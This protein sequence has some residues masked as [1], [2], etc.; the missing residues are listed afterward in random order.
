VKRSARRI[1]TTH[2]GSLARPLDL[3]E[4]IR[5]KE[6][7]QAVNDGEFEDR[8]RLAVE[9]IVKMQADCGIDV[10]SDGEQRRPSFNS[11]VLSRLTGFEIGQGEAA[12]T[13]WGQSA[14]K[15]IFA[16]FYKLFDETSNQGRVASPQ[17]ICTG[18]I[19]Y[20]DAAIKRDLENLR[21]AVSKIECEEAFMPAI[22]STAIAL[23]RKNFFYKSEE[24]YQIALADAMRSEYSAIVNAGFIVQVDDPRLVSHYAMTEKLPTIDE[25]R[26]WAARR[27][28]MINYSLQGIPEDKVRFHT[29]YSIDIGPRIHDLELKHIVDV[30]CGIRAGA[31]S[32]EFS[33][34]RHEH[35]WSVWKNAPLRDGTVLIPG[36]ISH[37]TN[38][39]E[40][41]ELIAERISRFAS[42]V[43][44][45]NVIAGAD[46]G[47]A[48]GASVNQIIHPSV[49]KAKLEA[50]SAGARIASAKLWNA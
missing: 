40:H 26:K 29:C 31:Y 20:R 39:V 1:L 3:V 13:H 34:P 32:F 33:N 50:L 23:A 27:V 21:N 45:E 30:I 15:R 8:V 24:Q 36:V 28:E 16:D 43:G 48:A 14:E 2:V 9:A 42:V 4:M 6:A 18:P 41:P 17:W 10:V 35:E 5:A 22:A 7:G 49:V 37:T 46:C 25:Y 38:L 19:Q 47:F 44:R 11:Y 12:T